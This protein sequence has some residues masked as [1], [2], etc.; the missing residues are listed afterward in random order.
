MSCFT[1]RL[2]AAVLGLAATGANAQ[3]TDLC[4][5]IGENGQWIGGDAAGS[6]ISRAPDHLE[7]MALVMLRDEYVALFSLSDPGPVRVE[8]AARGTGD[9]VID[10]YDAAGNIVASD[11]DSG[12]NTDSRAELTLDPGTYCLALR[13]FDG[14]PLTGLVRVG[15][16]EHP[17]LT[18]GLGPT[19]VATRGTCDPSAATPITLGAPL[20]APVETTPYYSFTLDQ[21]T[22]L[23]L[24]A[25]NQNADPVL[26]LYDAQGDWLAENDDFEGL[27]SR[28]DMAE[29]L[30]A[31]QYC[32]AVD[33]LGDTTLPVVTSVRDYDPEEVMQSL[34]DRAEAAPP[35]DGSYPVTDLGQVQTRQ[36]TDARVG[37][38]AAWHV[39]EVPAPGL[40]L[41]EAIAQG[42]GDPVLTLFDDLGRQLGHNDDSGGTLDSR[43]AL[44]VQPGTYL[45]AV[46]QVDDSLQSVIRVL[47]ERYVP[48][49]PE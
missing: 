21:P 5:G 9:T 13:S 6:D 28:I 8:A 25:E 12:G 24:T 41:I 2:A 32:L 14:S 19:P 31:G 39:V 15:R 35:L 1:L 43:L 18:E 30:P 23:S 3:Q 26:T 48:A 38:A 36:R 29:P 49:R 40:L 33:A 44:R 42:Q 45:V 16:P 7:Q 4:G 17:P 27:N 11:D 20:S 10:L 37:G 46:R 34:Y 22:A 47:F